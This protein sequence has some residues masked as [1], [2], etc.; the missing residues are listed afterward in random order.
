MELEKL[1][2]PHHPAFLNII[3]LHMVL[4]INNKLLFVGLCTAILFVIIEIP[5]T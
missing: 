2:N 4:V 5:I 3:A 1:N